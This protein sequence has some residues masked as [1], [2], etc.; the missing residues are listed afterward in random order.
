MS[1]EFDFSQM[2][3]EDLHSSVL[4]WC[5]EHGYEN[6][7][8]QQIV[9]DIMSGS[10]HSIMGEELMPLDDMISIDEE[11]RGK[12]FEYGVSLEQDGIELGSEEYQQRLEEFFNEHREAIEIAER[13]NNSN[14]GD[15]SERCKFNSGDSWRNA[16][17][18]Y[19]G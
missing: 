6:S 15:C 3:M 1:I 7:V 9:S 8:T 4:D 14:A 16:D 12:C 10:A 11:L 13:D 5:G 2:S 19:S 17:Y 18:G